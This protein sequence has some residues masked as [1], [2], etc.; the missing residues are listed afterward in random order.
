MF[1]PQS[2][3]ISQLHQLRVCLLGMPVCVCGWVCVDGCA[4]ER[5]DVENRFTFE[6]FGSR[7]AATT[8]APF[9]CFESPATTS[10]PTRPVAPVTNTLILSLSLSLSLSSIPYTSIH[11]YIFTIHTSIHLY[12]KVDR[13]YEEEERGR[14]EEVM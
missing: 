4:C 10:F 6:A 9:N 8:V 1:S 3:Q 5:R 7:V 14:R 13:C 12:I 11:L 2:D